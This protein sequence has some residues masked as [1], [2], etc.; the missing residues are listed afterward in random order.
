MVPIF[1]AISYYAMATGQGTLTLANGREMYFA[2]CLD[3]VVTTPLLLL[4]LSLTALKSPF[5][6]WAVLLGVLATDM[7]MIVTGAFA[8][9]SPSGS[10]VKWTWFIISSGAFVFIYVSLFGTLGREAVK[11]GEDAAKVFTTNRN[12]L[13][14]IW[15]A[16]PF[17]F[18]FG[19]EGMGS[20]AT[21]TSLLLYMALDVT[22]KVIFGVF[23]LR[24]TKA[25][26]DRELA[27]ALIP[28][29]DM[30]PAA[31][32]YAEARVVAP[33]VNEARRRA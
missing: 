12:I 17:V 26:T 20:I 1:A 4:G 19:P 27:K 30:R 21:A 3:W 16:Y 9:A 33:S 15:L 10:V 25:R 13:G 28:P 14:L 8:D 32:A 5:R 2:R 11:S 24:N 23:S 6:R 29:A 7:I 18:L 22:A 31:V